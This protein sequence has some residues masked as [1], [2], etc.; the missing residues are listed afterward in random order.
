MKGHFG[1]SVKNGL[2]GNEW[3]KV[4][5]AGSYKNL[6]EKLWS[7]CL[8]WDTNFVYLL[9]SPDCLLL[10]LSLGQRFTC[11][12]LLFYFWSC[13]KYHTLDMGSAFLRPVWPRSLGAFRSLWGKLSPIASGAQRDVSRYISPHFSLLWTSLRC[14]SSFNPSREIPC[15]LN[16][17]FVSLHNSTSVITQCISLSHIFPCLIPFFSSL[18]P[19][20]ADSY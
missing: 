3:Y 12:K 19:F 1:Y 5:L 7:L 16:D 11:A 17:L 10:L 13:R 9:R 6:K 14:S 8:Y 2:E 18:S 15:L 4:H 20:W